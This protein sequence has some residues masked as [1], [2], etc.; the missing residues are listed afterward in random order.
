MKSRTIGEELTLGWLS[1]HVGVPVRYTETRTEAMQAMPQGRGQR[2]DV[3]IGGRRDGRVTAYH[4][5][6]VQDAGAY[7]LMGAYLP[8]MTQRIAPGVYDIPNCSF[9]GVSVATNK[10]SVTARGPT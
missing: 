3:K 1:K 4:L 10:I 9:H 6:V 2:I 8:M 7:P 5:D